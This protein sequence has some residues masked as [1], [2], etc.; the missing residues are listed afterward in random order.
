ME[1]KKSIFSTAM[2]LI[3]SFMSYG[4]I[5]VNTIDIMSDLDE[6]IT[7]CISA[8]N[9]LG[10]NINWEVSGFF[11]LKRGTRLQTYYGPRYGFGS[12]ARWFSKDA[13]QIGLYSSGITFYVY[14]EKTNTYKLLPSVSLYIPIKKYDFIFKN[15]E[16]LDNSFNSD[17]L[18]YDRCMVWFSGKNKFGTVYGDDSDYTY[19]EPSS[20]VQKVTFY[21][22]DLSK[23]GSLKRI[24]I[25]KSNS[26]YI[27][28]LF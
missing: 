14:N 3:M 27:I 20:K 22:I 6:S 24:F 28:Q 25:S 8:R 15:A 5:D 17:I 12:S 4:Q 16:Q 11:E 21:I 13:T 7:M 2:L 26:K 10:S 23:L 1:Y 9:L 19:D 18:N